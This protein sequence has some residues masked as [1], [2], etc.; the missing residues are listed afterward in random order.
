MPIDS[1]GFLENDAYAG[2]NRIRDTGGG[3]VNLKIVRTEPARAV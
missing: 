3:V 2:A 1:A